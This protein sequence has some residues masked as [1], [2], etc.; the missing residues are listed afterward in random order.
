MATD[1]TVSRWNA[2]SVTHLP[3]YPASDERL[4]DSPELM[5]GPSTAPF[6]AKS[7]RRVNG[8][9]LVVSVGGSPE[10]WTVT[11]G[12]GVIYDNANA[13]AGPWKFAIPASKSANLPARPGVGLSRVDLLVARIYDVDVLGSGARE[14][15][16]EHVPGTPSASPST[17]AT[18]ALSLVLATL[19]VPNAGA[20]SVTQ[21]TA[22][23]VAAGG[24]LPV[25]TTAERDALATAGIAYS[26]LVVANAQ[27]PGKR[28]ERF[29]ATAWT[30]DGKW[31][32]YTP[33]LTGLA[34]AA[35][36]RWTR[37]GDLITVQ[38]KITAS[39]ASTTTVLLSKPT[40]GLY[41]ANDQAFG[42][43]MALDASVASSSRRSITVVNADADNVFFIVDSLAG[44]ATVIGNTPWAWANGDTLAGT[45]S[46]EA[47][48]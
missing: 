29:D 21:S 26:G 24:I 44:A 43:A 2:D 10:A 6:S 17:P 11:P 48:A 22:R 9:G 46:Y 35:T 5:P 1:G 15:K 16:I 20:I 8:A 34:G 19:N 13:T 31:A 4:L 45:F 33:A 7:G 28:L 39:G 18:P 14:I 47:A 36:A 3:A 40:S 25:A 27:A 38:F 23:V 12:A 32:D 41:T 37:I 42:T 30:Y